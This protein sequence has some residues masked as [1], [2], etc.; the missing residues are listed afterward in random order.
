MKHSALYITATGP[1]TGKSAIALG[2]M[3][4]LSRVMRNVGVFRPII[5]E[6]QLES[7]DP[8]INLL[9]QHFKLAQP[10]KETYAFTQS[11]AREI[12]NYGTRNVLI[13]N[14]IQKYKQV[15]NNFDFV[16]CIG[17]D[18]LGKDPVFE[19]ELNAEIA[20]NLGAPILL[21]TSGDTQPF[22]DI[23]DSMKL[24]FQNLQPYGL[25][26]IATIINRSSLSQTELDELRGMLGIGQEKALV[27]AIP[28]FCRSLY[29]NIFTVTFSVPVFGNRPTF[30]NR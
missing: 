10:Y 8:D 26:I 2:T 15:L 9:L 23:A 1:T 17:T 4:M 16:L 20:S 30:F 22:E 24:V 25:D 12:I 29:N 19:F 13:E 11:E 21:V 6:P 28:I 5:N 14:I 27:Y 18:F 7:R 3:Q